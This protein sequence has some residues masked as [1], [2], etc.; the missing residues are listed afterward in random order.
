[1]PTRRTVVLGAAA[2]ATPA[3]AAPTPWGESIKPGLDAVMRQGRYL[4]LYTLA[5]TGDRATLRDLIGQW[6]AIAG[7][8]PLAFAGRRIAT[9][10]PPDLAGATSRDAVSAIVAAAR[11]RRVVML[12]EAHN[13]SHHRQFLAV[14]LRALR[15]LGFTHLAAETFSS[16]PH[17][18]SVGELTSAAQVTPAHGFYLW[19]PV[20]AEAVREGI[21]LGYRLVAYEARTDQQ[22]SS[23]DPQLRT[24]LREQ[25][26]ADNLAIALERWPQARFVIHVGAGHVSEANQGSLG[27]MFAE[28]LKA[29]TGIDPLTIGQAWAGSFGPHAFDE[30]TCTAVLARFRPAAP[31]CVWTANGAPLERS[32]HGVDMAVYHPRLP[33]REGRPGWLAAD[34]AR[35]RKVVRLGEPLHEPALAQAIH[36]ADIDPAIPADQHP[37]AEGARR[38]V[39]YLRPGRYRLRLETATGFRPLGEVRIEPRTT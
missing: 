33:D 12:N 7:D 39:F 23:T 17:D 36:A 24:P 32:A 6:A 2:V 11:S 1:M 37:T 34:P 10:T 9:D 18:P 4:P 27:P 14:V 8:E 3:M 20:L 31:I 19:D 13:A 26:Q 25:A 22:G 35:R 5:R 38:L 15:P 28:R 29:K 21:A 16:E 30:N